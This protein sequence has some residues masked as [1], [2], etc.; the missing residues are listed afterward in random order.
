MTKLAKLEDLTPDIIAEWKLDKFTELLNQPPRK[1]W[2]K[3]HPHIKGYRYIPIERIEWLLKRIFKRHR[4]EI[5]GQGVAF[6]G[7]W[8]TV[9]VHYF[10]PIVQEWEYFDGIGSS[11]LQMRAKTEEEKDNNERVPFIPEN[12]NHGAL[13]MAFPN[14]KTIAVKDAC[15]HF[16]QLFGSDLNRKDVAQYETDTRLDDA[17][18]DRVMALLDNCDTIEKIES[19]RQTV[20]AEYHD[21]LDAKIEYLEGKNEN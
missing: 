1:A 6:N 5:T 15:D 12:I 21:L 19:I 18:K 3:N 2:I 17:V 13:S 8:V 4:I 14:A 7:V 9:R 11:Q 16:G 20:P 10:H